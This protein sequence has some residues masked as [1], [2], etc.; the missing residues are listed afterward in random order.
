MAGEILYYSNESE[1]L[2]F[3]VPTMILESRKKEE[4]KE[5]EESK[6][7][8]SSSMN[9]SKDGSSGENEEG[10]M[11]DGDEE[12]DETTTRESMIWEEQV[13]ICFCK[14]LLIHL[15]ILLG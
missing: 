1:E 8:S 13:F 10:E 11:V 3:H 12:W 9:G 5:D 4:E 7:P 6:D 2:V 14:L 15:C